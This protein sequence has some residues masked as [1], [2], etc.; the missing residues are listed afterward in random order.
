[1]GFSDRLRDAAISPL[2]HAE[3][4][5]IRIQMTCVGAVAILG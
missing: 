3:Q 1:M 5:E 2:G 4:M